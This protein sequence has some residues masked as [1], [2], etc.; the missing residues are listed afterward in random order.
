MATGSHTPRS[1]WVVR[2]AQSSDLPA[3]KELRLKALHDHPLAFSADYE[4]HRKA[5]IRFW[6]KYFDFGEDATIFLA[7]H[8]ADLVGMTGVRL[9]SSS[10]TRHHALIWGVYVHPDWR[11]NRMA[12]ALIDHCLTWAQTN[13]AVIA[14][15]GVSTTNQAAIRCYERCGF[16]VYATAPKTN[17]YEG[18]YYDE[19]LMARELGGP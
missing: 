11:G 14:T 8:D 18:M 16:K 15:L 5:G 9:G 2:A 19:L 4:Q 7:S 6:R 10:K 12:E 1:G 17:F 3:F 13:G